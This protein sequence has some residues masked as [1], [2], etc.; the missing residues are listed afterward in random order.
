MTN[1]GTSV[2]FDSIRQILIESIKISFGKILCKSIHSI[3]P[4]RQ[5]NWMIYHP[6]C[7]PKSHYLFAFH[8]MNCLFWQS[9]HQRSMCE[10]REFLW[11][12]WTIR[13]QY[14]FENSTHNYHSPFAVIDWFSGYFLFF[15]F[16]R[17]WKELGG[18]HCKRCSSHSIGKLSIRYKTKL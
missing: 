14:I 9:E 3:K 8:S 12:K 7:T 18:L 10:N 11:P 13:S 1:H 2:A 15:F 4:K 5:N 17:C 6:L 16:W